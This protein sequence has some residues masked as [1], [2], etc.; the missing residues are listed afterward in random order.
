MDK[1]DTSNWNQGHDAKNESSAISL[2][3]TDWRVESS[4]Q[5]AI[6]KNTEFGGNR[7]DGSESNDDGATNDTDIDGDESETEKAELGND[8]MAKMQALL[9]DDDSSSDDASD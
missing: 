4:E 6:D 9:T 7:H 1:E 3:G 8:L 5:V 2:M